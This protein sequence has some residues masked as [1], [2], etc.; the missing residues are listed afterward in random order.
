MLLRDLDPAVYPPAG[1][2]AVG[3]DYRTFRLD[4]N[5][6]LTTPCTTA[7]DV[8]GAWFTSQSRMEEVGQRNQAVFVGAPRTLHWSQ[9]AGIASRQG[10]TLATADQV[11][12]AIA[13]Y[14][15][16]PIFPWNMWVPVADATNL[17]MQVGTDSSG[18][19]T[20]ANPGW[21]EVD[22]WEGNLLTYRGWVPMM[23]GPNARAAFIT[24]PATATYAD[25][26]SR[27]Q[28]LGA[29]VSSIASIQAAIS[30]NGGQSWFPVSTNHVWAPIS[31]TYNDWVT[32]G[33][34]REVGL[35]H[36]TNFGLPEWGTSRDPVPYRNYV[37]L[38]YTSDPA[39]I[40][41][42]VSFI[43]LPPLASD[44]T[45][46]APFVCAAGHTVLPATCFP[47]ASLSDTVATQRWISEASTPGIN[48]LAMTYLAQPQEVGGVAVRRFVGIV[49]ADFP[50]DGLVAAVI[51][52]NVLAAHTSATASTC[53]NVRVAFAT[54]CVS[55]RG[56]V[57]REQW[58]E[59]WRE[60]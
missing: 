38:D 30:A 35:V 58:R 7:L 46:T 39:V 60:G 43:N 6:R 37:A 32:L 10:G 29:S 20:T 13:A 52:R 28:G 3:L 27:A 48:S 47:Q 24:S 26:V 12:S 45:G 5:T 59:G 8:T 41:G 17:W 11:R 23:P 44:L 56:G 42:S 19:G 14:G 25:I 49:A 50:G 2:P 15:G 51:N 18:L 31:D 54:V 22:T 16:V 57:D 36:S 34:D 33:T 40:P 9:A 21:G 1:L 53:K 55:G 4:D